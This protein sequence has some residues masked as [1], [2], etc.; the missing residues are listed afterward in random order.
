MP[1]PSHPI[2][3]ARRRAFSAALI[4]TYGSRALTMRITPTTRAR[5]RSSGVRVPLVEYA[6]WIWYFDVGPYSTRHPNHLRHR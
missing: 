4:R 6:R 5:L 2:V 1:R 3:L